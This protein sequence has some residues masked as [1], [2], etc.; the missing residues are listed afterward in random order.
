MRLLQ[1]RLDRLINKLCEIRNEVNQNYD[2]E[3]AV[4]TQLHAAE[5]SVEALAQEIDSEIES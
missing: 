5:E 4:E 1:Q 3:F 2:V